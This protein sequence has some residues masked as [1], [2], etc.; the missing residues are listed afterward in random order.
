MKVIRFNKDREKNV[1]A[2]KD[3]LTEHYNEYLNEKHPEYCTD[4]RCKVFV[5]K[6]LYDDIIWHFDRENN[7]PLDKWY[8][9]QLN[10]FPDYT[11]S[12]ESSYERVGNE[13]FKNSVTF[14]FNRV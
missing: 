3:V 8:C 11:I 4:Y 9:N 6:K 14:E 13:R 1:K 7:V 12:I 2:I 5:G 10:V